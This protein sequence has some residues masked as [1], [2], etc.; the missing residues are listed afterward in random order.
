VLIVENTNTELLCAPVGKS[1]YKFDQPFNMK[2]ACDGRL[3]FKVSNS[4]ADYNN[5]KYFAVGEFVGSV[6]LNKYKKDYT[7]LEEE[8]LAHG[9]YGDYQGYGNQ[10]NNNDDVWYK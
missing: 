1:K 2:C 10:N 8:S 4:L 6:Y 9:G 5:G 7:L 3:K